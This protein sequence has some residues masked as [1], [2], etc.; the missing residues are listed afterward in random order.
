MLLLD[1][2]VQD[3]ALLPLVHLGVWVHGGESKVVLVQVPLLLLGQSRCFA[4]PI[5]DTLPPGPLALSP[6]AESRL[7]TLVCADGLI[8]LG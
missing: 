7:R 1:V 4:V 6:G 8:Q 2:L 5:S 3:V